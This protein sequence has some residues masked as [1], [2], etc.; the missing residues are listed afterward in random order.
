[1]N[2]KVATFLILLMAHLFVA[3]QSPDM[4]PPPVPKPVDI[5]IFNI[6][7][8]IVLPILI[9]VAYFAYRNWQKKQHN[10]EKK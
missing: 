8:Y 2:L 7:L 9:V 5:D 6:V 10:R 3:G 1:M 4:Y